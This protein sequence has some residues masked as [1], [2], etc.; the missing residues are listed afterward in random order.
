[1]FGRCVP[2]LRF[3]I[4]VTLGAV[5][6]MPYRRFLVWSSI[7]GMVWSTWICLSASLISPAL[8]GYPIAA[9]IVSTFLGTTLIG[10]CIWARSH[11]GQHHRTA[12]EP[13]P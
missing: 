4:N 8:K 12:V 2:G 1:M 5:V 10:T 3:A 9:L 13:A 6:R 11:I 7:S